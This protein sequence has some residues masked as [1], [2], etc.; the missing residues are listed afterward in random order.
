MTR[1]LFLP[2]AGGSAEFWKPAATGL[3]P[4]RPRHFF[5]W[6]GLSA[7]PPDPDVRGIDDLVR[8]VRAEITEP[9]D[10][11]AQS[12][13]GLIA[14]KVAL[15]MPSRIRRLVLT[16]TSGGLPVSEL[17]GADWRRDY[18]R[19]YPQAER[20]IVDVKEDLSSRLHGV[21]MPTLLIWGD[22]DQ[23]SPVAVGERLRDALPDA[24]LAVVPGGNH[25]FPRTHADMIRPLM[26]DHLT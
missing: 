20:W 10:L 6:P 8:R 14:L 2:G 1:L 25:D 26:A 5:S 19:D 12:M 24:R 13:G 3:L 17:G 18:L 11:V 21:T 9:V 4:E 23:I 7:E 16:G 15:A 22:R